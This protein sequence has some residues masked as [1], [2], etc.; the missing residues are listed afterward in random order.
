MTPEILQFISD[1]SGI[2]VLGLFI[3][4]LLPFGKVLARWLERKIDNNN[5]PSLYE[6]IDVIQDNYLYEIK[7]T[8]KRI[9][10]KLENIDSKSTW[11][12]ARINGK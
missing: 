4:F 3:L 6:K 2:A 9:E 7:E 8:L 11:I 1:I 12:K 5:P 10:Q